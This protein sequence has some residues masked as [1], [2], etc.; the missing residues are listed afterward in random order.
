MWGI[1]KILQ[2]PFCLIIIKLIGQESEVQQIVFTNKLVSVATEY[3]PIK[4]AR[5][6]KKEVRTHR[7]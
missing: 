4:K 1:I 7:K 3:S 6:F 2:S 5:I